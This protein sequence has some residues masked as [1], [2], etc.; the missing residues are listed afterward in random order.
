MPYKN[1]TFVCFD[2]D[3]DIHYYRLMRAWKENPKIPFNSSMHTTSIRHAIQ[4]W[5]PP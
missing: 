2:G 1:K 4:V 5:R 3:T